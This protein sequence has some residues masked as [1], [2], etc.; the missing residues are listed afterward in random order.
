MGRSLG[1]GSHSTLRSALYNVGASCYINVRGALVARR[2]VVERSSSMLEADAPAKTAPADRVESTR[3]RRWR[4]FRWTFAF[5][6]A[7][8]ILD[9][10][11]TY[12]GFQRIGAAYEQN[13]IALYLIGHL[14]WVGM[15]ALI[16]LTC[17]VC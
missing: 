12:L 7:G 9:I 13:G 3:R 6:C 4:Y 14:G 8:I 15:C 11:T 16:A 5:T 10:V 2:D 17:L 1:R